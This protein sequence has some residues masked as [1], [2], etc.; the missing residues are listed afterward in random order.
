MLRATTCSP[1]GAIVTIEGDS[2]PGAYGQYNVTI[3]GPFL[4]THSDVYNGIGIYAI[5]HQ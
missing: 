1:D 3:N 5:A 2:G 4:P